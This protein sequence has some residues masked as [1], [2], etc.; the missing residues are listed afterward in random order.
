M[1]QQPRC[2][3]CNVNETVPLCARWRWGVSQNCRNCNCLLYAPCPKPLL[4]EISIAFNK[5]TDGAKQMNL[6]SFDLSWFPIFKFSNFTLDARGR[7]LIVQQILRR[8]RES[9][10]AATEETCEWFRALVGFEKEEYQN[11]LP[12]E[13]EEIYGIEHS[14]SKDEKRRQLQLLRNTVRARKLQ[15]LQL[16]HDWKWRLA[17]TYQSLNSVSVK[18]EALFSV[19]RISFDFPVFYQGFV[20]SNKCKTRMWTFLS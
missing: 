16:R 19:F 9:N 5:E 17:K 4:I 13:E 8:D 15:L 1:F 20:H 6:I 3:I 11:C 18:A 7:L 10:S 12:Q 2:M 14:E